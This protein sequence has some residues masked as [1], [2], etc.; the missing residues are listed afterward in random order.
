LQMGYMMMAINN[1]KNKGNKK[2]SA[3]VQEHRGKH[4]NLQVVQNRENLTCIDMHKILANVFCV[5]L[6]PLF[7]EPN[8]I[9]FFNSVFLL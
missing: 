9:Q 2:T 3:K 8:I 5:Y 7:A 4:Y 6:S 1:P